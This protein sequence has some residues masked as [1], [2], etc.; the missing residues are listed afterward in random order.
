MVWILGR[1]QLLGCRVCLGYPRFLSMAG[2]GIVSVILGT[3]TWLLCL[4]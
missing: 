1:E 3:F 2:A 4:T